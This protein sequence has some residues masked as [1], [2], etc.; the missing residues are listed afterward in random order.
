MVKLLKT[1]GAN[2]ITTIIGIVVGGP[3]LY[4][5]AKIAMDQSAELPMTWAFVLIGIALIFSRDAVTIKV[6][7]DDT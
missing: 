5:N 3:E 1:G 6:S 7:T 2:W 4:A